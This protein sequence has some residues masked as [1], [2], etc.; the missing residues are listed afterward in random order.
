MNYYAGWISVL[1]KLLD[2]ATR[3]Y[4]SLLQKAV[5][6]Q[7]ETLAETT[8]S[9]FFFFAARISSIAR[10]S[11]TGADTGKVIKAVGELFEDLA[12]SNYVFWK[13]LLAQLASTAY[14]HAHQFEES[15]D[16]AQKCK[17]NWNQC[18]DSDRSQAATILLTVQL[19]LPH[20][21][22]ALEQL[23]LS[24]I[25]D[26]INK[27]FPAHAVEKLDVLLGALTK[28][29]PKSSSN[30]MTVIERTFAIA[31]QLKGETSRMKIAGLYQRQATLCLDRA[32]TSTDCECEDQALALLEE[33]VKLYIDQSKLW[34][35]ANT[36]LMGGLCHWSR[37]TKHRQLI[38]AGADHCL[39]SALSLWQSALDAFKAI[40]AT[41]QIGEA[42]YWVSFAYFERYRLG[43]CSS[44]VALAH[45]TAATQSTDRRRSEITS[46]DSPNGVRI[47]QDISSS[48]HTRRLYEFTLKILLQENDLEGTWMCIQKMK[49]RSL[50]DLLG[51]GVLIPQDLVERIMQNAESKRL[52]N[53]EMGIISSI[54][55]SPATDRFALRLELADCREKMRADTV[56]KDLLDL[57]EGNP[58]SI[59]GIH[60]LSESFNANERVILVD[61]VLVNNQ[62]LVYTVDVAT[63]V[64]KR[65]ELTTTIPQL[66]A[67]STRNMQTDKMRTEDGLGESG[68]DS[69]LHQ[70][71]GLIEPLDH[72]SH[73]GD[74]IVI[75]PSGLLHSL[76]LHALSLPSQSGRNS[77]I[78]RN[79]VV[80]CASLTTF[81]QTVRKARLAPPAEMTDKVVVSVYEAHPEEAQFDEDERYSVY[82]CAEDIRTRVNADPPLV[83]QTVGREEFSDAVRSAHLVHFHGHCEF[84][85]DSAIDQ[86]LR[87]GGEPGQLPGKVAHV[88]KETYIDK[89]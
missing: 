14:L 45:I 25:T 6:G 69:C 78:D 24:M 27:N 11:T 40:D 57:R 87:L 67:W 74:L 61:Y 33:A 60:L 7:L 23:A 34:E 81:V 58:V 32:K 79:P 66:T 15:L 59:E 86:C 70:I 63:Q 44:E 53:H 83:G 39:T 72:V 21:S 22:K 12:D 35:A 13:G 55:G 77:L 20:T 75:S 19:E 49:A 10:L 56:L 18:L 65:F 85:K 42:N 17:S 71:D 31:K 26:D 50:S 48:E 43:W 54:K 89:Y 1:S 36:R 51:L 88:A 46:L 28:N 41:G 82:N 76:P 4:N 3:T 38:R 30:I 2:V 9:R 52:Y 16:W 80:Y 73:P 62:I 68:F 5:L 29:G 47:K 37:Y 84:N 8:G 64:I